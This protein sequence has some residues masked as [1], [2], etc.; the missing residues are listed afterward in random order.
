MISGDIIWC[1]VCGSYADV[2]VSGLTDKCTGRHTGVWKGGGKRGQLNDLRRNRHPRNKSQL[3]PPMPEST[4]ALD[5]A[6]GASH[7]QLAEAAIRTARYSA[8]DKAMARA[9]A[10]NPLAALTDEK[11]RWI[12][13]KR[14]EA[15]QR[16]TRRQCQLEQPMPA[17]TIGHSSTSWSQRIRESVT[18]KRARL[19]DGP[20]DE[21]GDTQGGGSS[22]DHGVGDCPSSRAISGHDIADHGKLATLGDG[23]DNASASDESDDQNDDDFTRCNECGTRQNWH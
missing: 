21:D 4:M 15:I 12:E 18:G 20:M 7:T 17:S 6:A 3:P 16:A 22:K 10:S 13:N 11:R 8:K 5:A 19:I 23:C 14:A 9:N 1:G 2:K